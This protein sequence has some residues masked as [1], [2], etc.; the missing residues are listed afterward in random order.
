M[1]YVDRVYAQSDAA[2]GMPTSDRSIPSAYFEN[3]EDK[4]Y[5]V[6]IF[7]VSRP[8]EDTL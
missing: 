8:T 2:A 7:E 6:V 4:G 1:M 3:F 5:T